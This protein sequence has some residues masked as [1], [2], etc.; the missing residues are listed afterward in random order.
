[1][2][3]RWFG[4]SCFLLTS[5]VGTRILTDP[6]GPGLGYR[7]PRLEA[8]IVTT[9]HR[10]MDHNYLGGVSG[11]FL[12]VAAPG[13]CRWKDTV[14]RGVAAFHDKVEGRKRGP[15]VMYRFMVDGITI[16]HLGDL[17]LPLEKTHLEALGKVDVLLLPVGGFAAM[18]VAEAVEVM[19]SLRPVVTV[20]M[21][22][23]TA[24]M[25]LVGLVFAP[26]ARFL[27]L[28]G[29]TPRRVR[30]LDLEPAGLK[31]WAGVVVLDYR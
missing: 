17:G 11:N 8:D 6:F 2:R 3:L 20:P 7:V 13:D 5:C 30:E 14:I 15:N 25:G 1:M 23:R 24:A 26:L 4:Q 18:S 31:E 21:H 10:H 22:Y 28:A 27:S 19:R 16:C 29:I 12:R 9:S